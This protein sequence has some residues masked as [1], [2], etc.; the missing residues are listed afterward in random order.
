MLDPSSVRKSTPITAKSCAARL[1]SSGCQQIWK[2]SSHQT[3]WERSL[4]SSVARDHRFWFETMYCRVPVSSWAAS[5][6]RSRGVGR[7]CL[8]SGI[9]APEFKVGYCRKESALTRL[10]GTSDVIRPCF[11]SD[12]F[13]R[14]PIQP[15]QFFLQTGARTSMLL[16]GRLVSRR[17]LQ[18]QRHADQFGE[19]LCFHLRHHV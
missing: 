15:S 16:L 6:P 17:D 9:K 1:F 18:E 7:I 19:T 3:S 12:R 13:R 4:K 2:V 11:A 8:T 5:S 14:Q 10:N